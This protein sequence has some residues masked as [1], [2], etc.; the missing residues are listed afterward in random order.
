MLLGSLFHV[1]IRTQHLDKTV[2]FYTDVMKMTLADRPPFDFPGAWIKSPLV[3]AAPAIHVY[4]GE[5]ALEENGEYLSGTGLVDHISFVSYGYSEFLNRFQTL[6]L[7]WRENRVV[8]THLAQ[9]FV[10]D[11]N[12]VLIEL[13]FDM[14]SEPCALPDVRAGHQYQPK[15]RWF[16]FARYQFLDQEGGE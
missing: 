10:Y 11:P 4:A 9:I 13:L 5:A 12:G 15:E 1:A 2:R 3:D 14:D 8:N 6:N 7:P 16:E